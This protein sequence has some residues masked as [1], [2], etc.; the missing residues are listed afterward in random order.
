MI[1][2]IYKSMQFLFQ[3]NHPKNKQKHK[4]NKLAVAVPFISRF[5]NA[6]SNER[7][8]FLIYNEVPGVWSY[9]K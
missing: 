1:A 6:K 3:V 9:I 8:E 4:E 5:R 2:I 7:Y